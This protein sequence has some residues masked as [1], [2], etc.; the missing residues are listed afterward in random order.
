[1]WTVALGVGLPSSWKN[2]TAGALVLCWVVSKTIFLVSGNGL[3][4]D[5]YI[6]PDLFVLAII[7]AK[8][9][10]CTFR[11]YQNTWDQ[12]KCI[13][14]E[15]SVPDR[16]VMLIFPVMWVIYYSNIHS[17]YQWWSLWMLSIIQ[18]LAAGWEGIGKLIPF[19]NSKAPAHPYD[20][21]FHRLVWGHE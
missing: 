8:P 20:D 9:E 3:A 7:F 10:I 6:F 11:P 21:M 4:T 17:Y 1:M 13:F 14:L 19:A 18:F 5:Y 12:F 15:R 2:P 16:I